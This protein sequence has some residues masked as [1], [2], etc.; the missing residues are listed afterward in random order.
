MKAMYMTCYTN[1][2]LDIELTYNMSWCVYFIPTSYRG[3]TDCA[4]ATLRSHNLTI[5]CNSYTV[6]TQS[7]SSRSIKRTEAWYTPLCVHMYDYA[8]C[9]YLAWPKALFIKFHSTQV[10]II[11]LNII[12][13]LFTHITGTAF[14]LIHRGV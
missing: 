11:S 10:K 4:S 5:S 7:A 1:K 2:V 14:R 3:T 9:N 13:R 12:L 6:H 8:W